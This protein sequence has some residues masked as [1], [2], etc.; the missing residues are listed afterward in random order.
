MARVRASER[1]GV[2]LGSRT[3]RAVSKIRQP[4]SCRLIRS[5]CLTNLLAL[6]FPLSLSPVSRLCGFLL[7]LNIDH[8]IPISIIPSSWL[9][10]ARSVHDPADHPS[11]VDY[12]LRRP[13]LPMVLL[14]TLLL[15]SL[16]YHL[17]HGYIFWGELSLFGSTPSP[18]TFIYRSPNSHAHRLASSSQTF[19]S[20]KWRTKW[21]E[22]AKLI[23][24]LG[25]I[26]SI[27]IV[28][29]AL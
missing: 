6:S 28:R 4:M 22:L 14:P 10:H 17:L 13:I 11:S 25:G 19:G 12:S 7:G 29:S 23:G 20:K 27:I 15:L 16:C 21:R 9:M 18:A 2:T 26:L 1:S 24:I 3:R 8:R 5:R